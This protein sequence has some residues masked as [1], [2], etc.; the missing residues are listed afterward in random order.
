MTVTEEEITTLGKLSRIAIEKE[1]LDSYTKQINLI[2]ELVSELNK[3]KTDNIKPISH[4]LDLKARLRKD[5]VLEDI[6]LKEK[7]KCGVEVD[8]LTIQTNDKGQS[9]V[10]ANQYINGQASQDLLGQIFKDS[11]PFLT[12]S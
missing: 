1:D 8:Q 9:V 2:L 3:A 5:K 10:A 11:I 12:I 6:P 4:P 7:L